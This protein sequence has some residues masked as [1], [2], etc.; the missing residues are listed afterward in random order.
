MNLSEILKP[1]L[2]NL[3]A[4][5]KL[6]L[7]ETKKVAIAQAWKILQLTIVNI[8]QK[9]ELLSTNETGKDKKIVAMEL[10]DSFYDKVFIVIDIP[11]VPPL[12]EPIIHKYVKRFLMVL[13]GSTIDAMVTT[14]R[15]TGIFLRLKNTN[16]LIKTKE[17]I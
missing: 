12:I 8:I 5:T 7:S 17:A 1:E 2:E 10:L 13:A 16:S 4:E 15:E 6:L 14:F 11:F 9:I 3:A